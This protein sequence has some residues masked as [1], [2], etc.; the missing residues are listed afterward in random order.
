MSVHRKEGRRWVVRWREEGRNRSRAFGSGRAAREFDAAVRAAQRDDRERD[1]V[2]DLLARALARA[3][4]D[5]AQLRAL[6]TAARALADDAD[7]RADRL[8]RS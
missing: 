7:R 6:A 1:L 2:A 3:G 5:P 4:D 8:G